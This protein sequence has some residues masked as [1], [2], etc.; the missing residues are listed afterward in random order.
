MAKPMW[1]FTAD[2]HFDHNG[3]LEWADRDFT[4][5]MEMNEALL[6]NWND[7]VKPKDIVVV[8]GDF[9]WSTGTEYIR[10]VFVDKLNGT[11]IF[12]KGN[13]DFWIRKSETRHLY[14]RKVEDIKIFVGHYAQRSWVGQ[15]NLH[16]H[17]HAKLE[18]FYNQLDVGVDNAKKLLG[19][20]RP[21][22]FSEIKEQ[23]SIGNKRTEEMPALY[24]GGR[25][26]PNKF[27][28]RPMPEIEKGENDD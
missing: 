5:I 7:N 25:N 11:K 15:F 23:I 20:Y 8:A 26:G 28:V 21:F 19:D 24:E 22:K 13:H 4:N 10:K 9:A 1:H 17:S 18:P 3:S 6:K 16:G 12:L 14:I 2:T 27:N